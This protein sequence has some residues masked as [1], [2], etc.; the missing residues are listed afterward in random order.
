TT[1]AAGTGNYA[2]GNLG[3]GTYFVVETVPSGYLQTGPASGTFKVTTTS[4]GDS[5][6]ND[7]ANF[8][9][10]S[11][12]GK[13]VLDITGNGV[14]TDDTGL[15]GITITLYKDAN[16]T[17]VYDAGDTV[18]ATTTTTA[19]TGAYAFNNVAPGKYFVVETVPSGYFQTVPTAPVYYTVT[20]TSGL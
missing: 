3:P 14:T 13:K 2:F 7:F 5:T 16:N 11:I 12:S 19:G 8:Q 17:G 1:S 10:A 9:L 15:G 4:L 18:A 20:A 6:G